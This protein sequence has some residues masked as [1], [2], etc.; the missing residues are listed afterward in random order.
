MHLKCNKRKNKLK[1]VAAYIIND[2]NVNGKQY[3]C[4]AFC[5]IINKLI[6]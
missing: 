2:R 5:K 6:I 3:L 1:L 4:T